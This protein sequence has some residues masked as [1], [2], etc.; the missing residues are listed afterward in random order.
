MRVFLVVS[1]FLGISW[2]S[3][4]SVMAATLTITA[5]NVSKKFSTEQ[6]QNHKSLE[7]VKVDYDPAYGEGVDIAYNAV[8]VHVLFKGIEVDPKALIQFKATDDFQLRYRHKS[9]LTI[10]RASLLLTLPL[11][12]PRNPGPK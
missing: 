11:K 5:D 9:F 10:K 4:P 12:I 7:V 1:L 8:P 3:Q 2:V 6:L